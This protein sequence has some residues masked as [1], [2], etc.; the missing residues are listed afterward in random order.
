[1]PQ[2]AKGGKFVFGWCTIREDLTVSL[3]ELTIQEY[4]LE[5]VNRLFLISGSKTTGG[6][7]VSHKEL[8]VNSVFENIT[9]LYPDLSI[10]HPTINKVITHNGRKYV[11]VSLYDGKI[12]LTKEILSSYNLKPGDKLLSIRSSN[13]AF[14]MGVKGPLLEAAKG[15]QGVI[16]EF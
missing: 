3:P 1:M 5:T 9:A 4:A 2:L 15:Y 10:P 8:L 16:E 13:I 7:S 11:W 12:Q 6:F 14:M